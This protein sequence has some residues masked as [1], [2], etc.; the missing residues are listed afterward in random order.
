MANGTQRTEQNAS[1]LFHT[2]RD[3][4]DGN[5]RLSPS[6]RLGS[7]ASRLACAHGIQRDVAL[8]SAPPREDAARLAR[9][10]AYMYDAYSNES[11]ADVGVANFDAI[12]P[13]RHLLIK[14]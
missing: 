14:V 3:G 6:P 10:E 7:E 4:R 12:D 1:V 2:V 13:W 11:K 9:K 5:G 8:N